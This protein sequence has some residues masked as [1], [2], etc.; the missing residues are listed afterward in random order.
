MI[1][2]HQGRAENGRVSVAVV[3]VGYGENSFQETPIFYPPLMTQP[4]TGKAWGERRRARPTPMT[5]APSRQAKGCQTMSHGTTAQTTPRRVGG[6]TGTG[7]GVAAGVTFLDT[8]AP[9]WQ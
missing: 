1:L 6:F 8:S 9:E 5:F 3:P 4:L 7:L 2:G